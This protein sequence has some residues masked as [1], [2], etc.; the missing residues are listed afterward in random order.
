MLDFRPSYWQS[1]YKIIILFQDLKELFK[2]TI[3]SNIIGLALV[4]ITLADQALSHQIFKAK[5]VIDLEVTILRPFL[6]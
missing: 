2:N 4:K 3:M 6:L 1:F 5:K